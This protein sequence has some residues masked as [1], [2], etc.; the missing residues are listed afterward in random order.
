[1]AAAAREVAVTFG[2]LI[3]DY[4]VESVT[5]SLRLPTSPRRALAAVQDARVSS[6]AT[7]F[8]VLTP[9]ASQ[10]DARWGLLLATPAWLEYGVIVCVDVYSLHRRLFAVPM[11]PMSSGALIL[12][13]LNLDFAEDP[14]VYVNG[15]GPLFA[16]TRKLI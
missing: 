12:D 4:A 2:V 14:D 5:V 1:M 9:V 3:P 7:A 15:T 13:L 11:P 6:L 8:P 16:L 10:P